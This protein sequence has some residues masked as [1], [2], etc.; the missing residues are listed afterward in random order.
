MVIHFLTKLIKAKSLSDR[1]WGPGLHSGQWLAPFV[2]SMDRLPAGNQSPYN[3]LRTVTRMESMYSSQWFQFR[4]STDKSFC[5]CGPQIRKPSVCHSELNGQTRPFFGFWSLLQVE[6][7]RL[8]WKS[9]KK[10]KCFH[11]II[12]SFLFTIES[13]KSHHRLCSSPIGPN[14]WIIL[15]PFQAEVFQNY[16]LQHKLSRQD[17]FSPHKVCCSSSGVQT[18]EWPTSL[19][20][21]PSP[22]ETK[23][24]MTLYR[25]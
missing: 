3:W 5:Q 11:K 8:F 25:C 18:P 1:Q 16:S 19:C 21:H 7:I 12:F 13:Q 14:N 23:H 22:T 15:K 9:Y 10:K 17:L 6:I 24:T 20:H 4:H 2:L